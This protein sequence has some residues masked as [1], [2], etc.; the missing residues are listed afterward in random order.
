M[1]TVKLLYTQS[2][3]FIVHLSSIYKGRGNSYHRYDQKCADARQDL[4]VESSKRIV[5]I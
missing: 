5:E 1:E 2:G 4:R 3:H